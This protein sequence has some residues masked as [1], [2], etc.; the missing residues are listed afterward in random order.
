MKTSIRVFLFVLLV[1]AGCTSKNVERTSNDAA[2][3]SAFTPGTIAV[4]KK[5][6]PYLKAHMNNGN[7][8]VFTKWKTD[9]TNTG[10]SG[11]ATLFGPGRD[12]LGHGD[13]W[14]PYSD[15]AII[16]TN[17]LSIS[18]AAT[19]MTVFT[20]I[21][22]AMGVYCLSNP[23]ACFGS[24]PT[25]YA[26]DGDSLLLQGEG[27]SS[28][29]APALEA[30]DVDA[31]YR[32]RPRNGIMEILMRNEALETHVVRWV[33][34]LAVPTHEGC[35]AFATADGTFWE[36]TAQVAPLAA[37]GPEGDCVQ[38]IAAFDGHERFSLADAHDL[39]S[40]ESLNLKFR[41]LPGHRY[42]LV[43][44]CRQ[45]LLPTYLLY[46]TLAYMGTSVATWMTQI[47]RGK[48]PPGAVNMERLIG[49]IN[50]TTQQSDGSWRSEGEIAEHGP[51]AVDVHL[52]PLKE[53]C[54]ST[55]NLRL[56]MTKGT[57]R[58]DYVALA[59]LSQPVPPVRIAPSLVLKGDVAD[60]VALA[61]LCDSSKTLVTLPGDRYWLKYRL[62]Q[63]GSR[64]EYFIESRGYYLEW[65]RKEWI[66]E[67]NPAL[68]AQ[69][70]LDPHTALRNL[71]P[72]YKLVE[73]LMEDCFW[74]SRYGKQ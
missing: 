66:A 5:S 33:N 58:I 6:S 37:E 13:Y 3:F 67:E 69:M 8:Y 60:R 11:I 31:L 54:D 48:L 17:E 23:K 32:V 51:L 29:V 43:V 46:Q 19:A 30:T 55:V 56:T 52:L 7:V 22:V 65:M 40:K 27:F 47:E 1:L 71:A 68:L 59:E 16:E 21:T 63:R 62:P 64:Y 18:G 10:I 24:C 39:S 34:L 20:G 28:S 38:Q 73:P 12:T 72:Q 61:T 25:F 70:F 50:A 57:W 44:A 45:G 9:S 74:R 53:I 14:L 26:S 49:G 35:R 2:T 42:G 15:I 36:S 41:V 4:L